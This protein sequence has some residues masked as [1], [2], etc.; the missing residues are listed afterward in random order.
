MRQR[1]YEKL[2]AYLEKFKGLG[3][4]AS[5]EEDEITWEIPEV[6][7]KQKPDCS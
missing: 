4:D 6:E 5:E 1:V 3:N 2:C 7:N